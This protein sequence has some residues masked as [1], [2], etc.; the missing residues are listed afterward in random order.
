MSWEDIL[1]GSKAEREERK[2][3]R[4]AERK[5]ER[6]KDRKIEELKQLIKDWDYWHKKYIAHAEELQEEYEDAKNSQ[7]G[8]RM[9]NFL[10]WKHNTKIFPQG[11]KYLPEGYKTLEQ[12]KN[13]KNKYRED[14][15][16][17]Q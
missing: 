10:R 1:K 13:V 17:L 4:A 9:E 8:T 11:E 14:L 3:M 2:K 16:E 15:E 5:E 12:F 7:Y 6:E